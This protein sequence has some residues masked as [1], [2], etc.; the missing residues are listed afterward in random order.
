MVSQE[1]CNRRTFYRSALRVSGV[2]LKLK[3]PKVEKK[4]WMKR[5]SRNG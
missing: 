1:L 4:M 2:V 5:N 3:G